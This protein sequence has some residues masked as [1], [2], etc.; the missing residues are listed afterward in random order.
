MRIGN[1][2]DLGQYLRDERLAAGLSQ[3]D[4]AARAR[5]S[6]RWLSDIEGG[7]PTAEIGLVFRVVAALDMIV[8]LRPAPHQDIDLDKLLDSLGGTP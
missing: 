8:E 2:R 3:A 6:R 7:K 5:V 4:L 1:A